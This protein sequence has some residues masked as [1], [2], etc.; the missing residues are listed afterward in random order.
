MF[1]PLFKSVAIENSFTVPNRFQH[2]RSRLGTLWC[3]N[4]RKHFCFCKSSIALHL[5]SNHNSIDTEIQ[6]SLYCEEQLEEE[7][8]DDSEEEHTFTTKV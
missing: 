6:R 8:E 4:C 1:L 7:E 3:T 2:L 5:T